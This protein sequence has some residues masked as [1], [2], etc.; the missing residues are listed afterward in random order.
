M[1]D[2]LIHGY[3]DVDYQIVWNIIKNKIPDL[4]QKIDIIISELDS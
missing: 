3:F 2:K 4:I 1:R